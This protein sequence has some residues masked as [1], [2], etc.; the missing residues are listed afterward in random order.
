MAD[1]KN[2]ISKF[3][4]PEKVK[5]DAVS[6]YELIAEA[7]SKAH[8]CEI[9]NIHFH[10]V[11]T[12]DAV[13]DIVGVCLLINYLDVDNIISSPINVG[14][15]TVKC[16]H[17]IL[18]VPAPATAYILRDVPI[19]SNEVSGELCTPTGA[20]LLKYFSSKFSSMPTMKVEKIG[21]GMGTKDFGTA[22]CVRAFIGETEDK[23]DKVTEL[24]CNIDD[25]SGERIAF[26]VNKLFK[27]GALDVYTTPIG[28][29][30]NRPAVLLTC[31]CRGEDK[32]KLIHLIF[33][34]TSTIGIRE[35]TFNRYILDRK[36][37][38]IDTKYG[39]VR[40]KKSSGYGVSK[41]KVE[42]DDLERI[43]LENDIDISEIKF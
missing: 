5:N 18:P 38:K 37:E 23:V 6:V 41:M 39:E 25:M 16:A 34:Y 22:N 35:N 26:A 36:E 30:K 2:L 7:E 43:A 9:E 40:V 3:D 33:K 10:E 14:K 13:A 4:L 32:E 15:G 27:S 24:S 29:K 31:I 8:N 20:A 21:Y 17:G 12:M 1:I 11:G 19:Y 28:M 42:Y